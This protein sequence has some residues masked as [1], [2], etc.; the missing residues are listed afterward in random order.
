[1][2]INVAEELKSIGKTTDRHLEENLEPISFGG[3]KLVFTMPLSVDVR[4]SFDGEGFSVSGVLS[5]E[6]LMHCTKCNKEFKQGFNIATKYYLRAKTS[7]SKLRK[8][9]RTRRSVIRSSVK[10]SNST[11]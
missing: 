11:K 3:N 2:Q 1:M 4:S 6:L 9:R 5:S 8:K 10:H 7:L